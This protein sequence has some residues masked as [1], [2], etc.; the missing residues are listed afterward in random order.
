MRLD[1]SEAMDEQE[2]D[3]ML[4]EAG[5][6][7]EELLGNLDELPPASCEPVLTVRAI[8]YALDARS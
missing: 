7:S 3:S 5:M 1:L 2:L 6:R 8:S 4:I